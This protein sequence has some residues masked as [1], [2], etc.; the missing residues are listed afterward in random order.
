[1]KATKS[2]VV[3]IASSGLFL[4]V[5]LFV[6]KAF[7]IDQGISFS[8]HTLFERVGLFVVVTS[9]VYGINELLVF[10]RWA[11]K[12]R[13][14]KMLFIL[15]EVFSAG[16]AVFLLFNFF[17]NFTES[18]WSAYFLLLA[19]FS[20]VMAIPHVL[21]FLLEQAT[22]KERPFVFTSE[23]GKDKVSISFRSLQYLKAEDNYVS[24][25]S[26]IGDGV[27][28]RLIR[29]KLSEME[30]QHPSLV[31]VHRSYLINPYAVQHIDQS[32]KSTQVYFDSGHRVPVSDTYKKRLP[33]IKH[34]T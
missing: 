11:P 13:W 25:I 5:A 1:M 21:Y 15:W 8:G 27:N 3:L 34:P 16:S 23:N 30:R 28:T 7:G 32:T 24:I 9:L 22:Q 2:Q 19:E 29:R 33:T 31:R 18:Y 20:S 12:A 14:H 10:R 17:W 26:K 6:Y 4:G